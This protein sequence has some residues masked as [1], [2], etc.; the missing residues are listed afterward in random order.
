[1]DKKIVFALSV[2]CVFV[3]IACTKNTITDK[4]G[5]DYG[6]IR[7]QCEKISGNWLEDSKEC[8]GISEKDCKNLGGTFNEC[9]SACRND[10]KAKMCTEQCV[11]VCKFN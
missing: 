2:F 7:K 6:E 9:A 5:T 1:M 4:P 10:P 8:E 3:F 11:I